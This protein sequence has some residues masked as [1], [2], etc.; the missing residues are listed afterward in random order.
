MSTTEI[1]PEESTK[2]FNGS[3]LDR[4]RQLNNSLPPNLTWPLSDVISLCVQNLLPTSPLFL[5]DASTSQMCCSWIETLP[6]LISNDH[7]VDDFLAPGI[8]AL[9]QSILARSESGWAPVSSALEVQLSSMRAIKR[10][11]ETSITPL[12]NRLVAATMCLLMSEIV[13][14]KFPPNFSI[15]VKGM[16]DLIYHCG[17]KH[18][19]IGSSQRL[20]VA[21]RPILVTNAIMNRQSTFLAMKEWDDVPFQDIRAKPFQV[22]ISEASHIPAIL[23]KIDGLN[24]N[25]PTS[26]NAMAKGLGLNLIHI[27]H[28][29]NQWYSHLQEVIGYPLCWET[30]SVNGEALTWFADL[31]MATSLIHFWAFWIICAIE[32]RKL[33]KGFPFL[34]EAIMHTCAQYLVD[35]HSVTAIFQVGTSILQSMDFFSQDAMN[36]VGIAEF[37]FPFHI[38]IISLSS[39]EGEYK[40]L[41]SQVIETALERSVGA[42]FKE[43]RF[44][45]MRKQ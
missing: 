22:L 11:L 12:C 24:Y 21:L 6:A 33:E 32:L 19:S 7:G 35:S 14:S 31:I 10:A 39:L 23:E 8:K 17:P 25:N 40:T 37:S 45:Y 18:Y 16:S 38:A 1:R 42:R 27:M 34:K 20:F 4:P 2:E 9:G 36:F 29:L 28:R 30:V 43:I 15:H 44:L 13:L 3:Q 26:A 5:Q 41:S